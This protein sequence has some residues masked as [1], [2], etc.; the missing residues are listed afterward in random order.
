[1]N[2][3]KDI[4]TVVQQAKSKDAE[5]EKSLEEHMEENRN[6]VKTKINVRNIITY[7]IM[8]IIVITCLILLVHFCE[9]QMQDLNKPTTTIKEYELVST[10][11]VT[12]DTG[13]YVST[14]RLQ[15]AATH[16][17]FDADNRYTSTKQQQT[18]TNTVVQHTT[19]TTSKISSTDKIEEEKE[20]EKEQEEE[21]TTDKIE[22]EPIEDDENN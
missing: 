20:E 21:T 9:K 17:V 15:T 3:N 12:V 10:S 6:N 1:M 5:I 19:I 8:S 13:V 11:N 14:M 4:E 18:R 22:E 16:T 7:L 2:N